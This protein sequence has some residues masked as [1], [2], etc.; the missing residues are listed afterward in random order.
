MS[1]GLILIY[2]VLKIMVVDGLL[3]NERSDVRLRIMLFVQS[4]AQHPCRRRL[5]MCTIVFLPLTLLTGYFVSLSHS[6]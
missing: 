6:L 1:W 3:R 4:V 2:S 5:T